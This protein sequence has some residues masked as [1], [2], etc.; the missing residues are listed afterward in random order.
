[1]EQANLEKTVA[2]MHKLN[3]ETRKL[4]NESHKLNAEAT[5]T[6]KKAKWYELTLF[7]AAIAA[8]AAFTKIFL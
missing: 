1:M 4:M 8:T 7:F 3:E 2:E 5:F 6:N